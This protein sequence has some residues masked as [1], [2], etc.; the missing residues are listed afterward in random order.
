MGRRDRHTYGHTACFY[1]LPASCEEEGDLFKC[2]K[3][4]LIPLLVGKCAIYLP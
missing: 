4:E 2:I 1:F 3:V